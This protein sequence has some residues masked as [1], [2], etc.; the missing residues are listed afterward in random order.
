[1]IVVTIIHSI[2]EVQEI[3]FT[4]SLQSR[5]L[6]GYRH[7]QKLAG[8]GAALKGD[9]P[10]LYTLFIRIYRAGS[11]YLPLVVLQLK[12]VSSTPGAVDLIVPVPSCEVA[13][14]IDPA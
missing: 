3:I 9:D 12:I 10:F 7:I 11:K 14:R 1:M 5:A 8:P 6:F 2:P 4:T 13:R